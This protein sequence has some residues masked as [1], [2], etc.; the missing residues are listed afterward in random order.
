MSVDKIQNLISKT[1]DQAETLQTQVLTE[2][3]GGVG[4]FQECQHMA[5]QV[6][7]E[8]GLLVLG[9]SFHES[10]RSENQLKGRAAR[11]GDPGETLM[12]FDLEDPAFR[13]AGPLLVMFSLLAHNE[14]HCYN[15]RWADGML[16]EASL[17]PIMLA[18]EAD[19]RERRSSIKQF[20][21][22]LETFRQHAYSLRRLILNGSNDKSLD[23]LRMYF[24]DQA[25]AWVAECIDARK[26]ISSWNWNEFRKR[27]NKLLEPPEPPSDPAPSPGALPMPTSNGK[28]GA[29]L[30]NVTDA[31][32]T[33]YSW[34][35][36]TPVEA[37]PD[38]VG[39]NGHFSIAVD[40]MR[41][42][43]VDELRDALEQN[44]PL[45][46]PAPRVLDLQYKAK[47]AEHRRM[48]RE[49]DKT[50]HRPR[51]KGRFGT[52]AEH[53]RNWLGEYLLA[54]YD[55]TCQIN[56]QREIA[57]TSQW[58]R[59]MMLQTLDD[60]WMHFLR[61]TS[62][63]QSGVS[64]RSFS[65]MDPVQE[66]NL[67]AGATFVEALAT[68]RQDCVYQ[69]FRGPPPEDALRKF[70]DRLASQQ[71]PKN[72]SAANLQRMQD[73]RGTAQGMQL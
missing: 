31:G 32:K 2:H 68:F 57:G 18:W 66:F 65:R 34:A 42:W 24:Q 1:L 54:K 48:L 59:F 50:G 28:K 35:T 21:E 61:E 17:R 30:L 72:T 22:V 58:E 37:I 27:V 60:I 46:A 39:A 16:L 11:Q 55:L 26:P 40:S 47:V 15:D 33:A 71:K 10:Q 64:L 67:E 45:Q 12:M 6:R 36:G 53:L 43:E 4:N 19:Y 9:T 13:N 49:S 29:P 63:L 69:A 73:I 5:R 8:G 25:D 70:R 3:W 51:I 38:Y 7:D 23:M 41:E 20:D 56:P 62:S 52:H 14:K 44:M